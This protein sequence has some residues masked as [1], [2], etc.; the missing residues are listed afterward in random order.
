[1]L[2]P[3]FLV[4][5]VCLLVRFSEI[6]PA[7]SEVVFHVTSRHAIGMMSFCIG[8]NPYLAVALAL[9]L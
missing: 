5:A 8:T 6:N 4:C 7:S 2:S 3:K 1:M 9:A